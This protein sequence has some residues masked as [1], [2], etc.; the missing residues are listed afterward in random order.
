M[1]LKL[2]L[3]SDRIC[4]AITGMSVYQFKQ[5]ATQFEWNYLEF[6]QKA[7][8]RREKLKIRSGKGKL[9][10]QGGRP[11]GFKTAEEMLLAALL[12]LK[13]YPTFD[14]ME[15]LL[16]IPRSTCHRNVPVFFQVL[17]QTLGRHLV[18]PKRK[19]SSLEEFLEAFPEI[20]QFP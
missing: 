12:Y 15:F 9:Q 5:L 20:K 3:K 11:N 16:N 1:N 2:A 7:R 10:N 6:K 8:D 14:L 17:E 19:I 13:V 18:L 4:R